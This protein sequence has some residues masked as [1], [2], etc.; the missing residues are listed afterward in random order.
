MQQKFRL[1]LMMLTWY[2]TSTARINRPYPAAY[3][4]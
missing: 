1:Q 4:K 2:F 3:P